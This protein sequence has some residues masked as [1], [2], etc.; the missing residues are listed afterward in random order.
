MLILLSCIVTKT[1]NHYFYGK[2]IWYRR[3]FL[4]LDV[5]YASLKQ[6]VVS[7]EKAYGFLNF[8]SKWGYVAA[9]L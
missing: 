5:Y 4:Q 1:M 2:Y 9:A 6:E 8:L 3:N 7:Q